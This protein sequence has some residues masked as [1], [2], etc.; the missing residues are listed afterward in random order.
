MSKTNENQHDRRMVAGML[1]MDCLFAAAL[2]C[3]HWA[4]TVST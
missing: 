3:V 1:L 2:L 4:T